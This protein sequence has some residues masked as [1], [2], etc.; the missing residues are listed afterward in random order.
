M[1]KVIGVDVG[2]TFTDV[3]TFDGDT[4][5]GRKV[6]TSVDQSV[7]VADAVGGDGGRRIPARKQTAATNALI[8]ERGGRV[9]LVTD[10]GYED[11]LE[12]GRQDRPSLYDQR[13]GPTDTPGPHVNCGSAIQADIGDCDVVA[14]VLIDSYKGP[15]TRTRDCPGGRQAGA[16][17]FGHL[18]GV[19]R[20]RANCDNCAFCLSDTFGGRLSPIVGC[21]PRNENAVS[22]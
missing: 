7:A 22:S 12:I 10:A 9:A 5:L 17:V 2:G 1:A 16:P 4:I 18:T 11:L 3:I 21:P 14:V 8:E 20:V 13:C 19:P 15:F 6:P